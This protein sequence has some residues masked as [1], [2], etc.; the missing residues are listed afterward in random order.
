MDL[1]IYDN[2]DDASVFQRMNA[3][4]YVENNDYSAVVTINIAAGPRNSRQLSAF[5]SALSSVVGKFARRGILITFSECDNDSI[6][7]VHKFSPS[8]LID[9]LLSANIHIC[10]APFHIGLLGGTNRTWTVE[11]LFN[12]IKRLEYHVG[13]PNG[14]FATDPVMWDHKAKIHTL[15]NE[16]CAPT[17]FIELIDGATDN[18]QVLANIQRFVVTKTYD[19]YYLIGQRFN[20]YFM[21]SFV[22][23]VHSNPRFTTGSDPTEQAM[24]VKLPYTQSEIL[25]GIKIAVKHSSNGVDGVL[26]SI[27]ELLEGKQRDILIDAIPYVIIQPDIMD[28]STI[29][30]SLTLKFIF[31]TH[32]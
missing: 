11:N 9:W 8:Q 16:Y 27:R 22:A 17:R 15:L 5:H 24:V 23:E 3:E 25:A 1:S 20:T 29:E 6:R 13:I 32:V 19:C 4:V 7:T 28:N 14:K 21:F 10:V 30:V 18:A 26:N 31:N 2:T 12:N